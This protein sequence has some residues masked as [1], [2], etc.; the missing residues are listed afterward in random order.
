[1]LAPLA[2]DLLL[3]AWSCL[4]HTGQHVGGSGA[5]KVKQEAV[6]NSPTQGGYACSHGSCLSVKELPSRISVR[7]L[8]GN[9]RE[10][11]GAEYVH[12]LMRRYGPLLS[13]AQLFV[14]CL[15]ATAGAHSARSRFLACQIGL[16]FSYFWTR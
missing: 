9:G 8:V 1:M 15:R 13:L 11:S 4:C 3:L 12:L 16:G 6:G 2:W 14:K 7:Q 10:H 5:I